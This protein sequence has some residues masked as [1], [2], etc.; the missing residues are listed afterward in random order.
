MNL[1]STFAVLKNGLE[2]PLFWR[3]WIK[4]Q[5]QDVKKSKL[6]LAKLMLL[7]LR[8][9][10]KARLWV[11]MDRWFLCGDFFD[12]LINHNYD[13]VT[14]AKKNTVLYVKEESGF[15]KINPK[16]L[17][18]NCYGKLSKLGKDAVIII[19]DIYIRRPYDTF[20]KRGTP[21]RKWHFVPIAAVASTY[22][23]AADPI[24]GLIQEEDET[25]TYKD[26]FLLI[27]N[28]SDAPVE[29]AK[30]YTKRWRIEV[31]YRTTKQE[32]G[33]TNCHSRCENA[34][35]AHIELLFLAETL[36]CFAKWE[37]NKEGAV[38]ALSHREMVRYL[39]NA[40]HRIICY[41]QTIQIYFDTTG[42]IFS[43]FIEKFWPKNL[44]LYLWSWCYFPATA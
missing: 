39:F 19:P 10:C 34:H 26:A 38:E 21:T 14:K 5:D 7:D 11:A 31:F 22:K 40:S 44:D 8:I 3:F 9:S 41:E 24:D 28:R 30:V 35:L 18:A 43:S 15:K 4:S 23:K 37:C 6:E 13:W 27:S 20:T 12:W 25:A 42:A 2:Y 16:M 1:V 29:V 17:L 32:L 36:L 33:L